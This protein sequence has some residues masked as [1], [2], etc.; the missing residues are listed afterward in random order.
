MM[1]KRKQR[2]PPRYPPST[3]LS[4]KSLPRRNMLS[5]LNLQSMRQHLPTPLPSSMQTLLITKRPYRNSNLQS[6]KLQRTTRLKLHPKLHG[7]THQILPTSLLCIV[8]MRNSCTQPCTT[9]R[10]LPR[11]T[12]V[13]FIP[14]RLPIKRPHQ[15]STRLPFITRLP[16]IT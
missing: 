7:I 1:T 2:S 3:L 9:Q 8:I 10:Q 5:Q 16:C 15:F 11:I 14:K 12:R 6:T 4:I 13:S